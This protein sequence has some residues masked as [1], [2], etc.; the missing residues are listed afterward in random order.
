[1]MPL[2][3]Y[4][5]EDVG[6]PSKL[7]A[8]GWMVED[9]PDYVTLCMDMNPESKGLRFILSIPRCAI[10]EIARLCKFGETYDR[11]GIAVSPK[12]LDT[13]SSGS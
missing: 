2:G 11:A 1:M 8:V 13:K 3:T 9:K 4:W 7:E 10:L 6:G 12:S 5:L